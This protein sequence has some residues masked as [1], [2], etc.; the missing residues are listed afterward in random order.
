VLS[1]THRFHGYGSLKGVYARGSSVRTSLVT[2]KYLNRGPAKKYRVAVVVSKKVSKSAVTRNRIRRRLYEAVRLQAQQL[3]A[4]TDLVLT[5]FAEQVA[6]IESE[7]LQKAVGEILQK[8][9]GQEA[10]DSQSDP[11]RAIVKPEIFK[12][13]EI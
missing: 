6:T 7:K 4:G 12:K 2:A 3:P 9:S 10:S 13:E 8:I 5:V 11:R 1:G